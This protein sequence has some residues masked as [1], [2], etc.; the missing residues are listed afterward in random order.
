MDVFRSLKQAAVDAWLVMLSILTD[1]VSAQSAMWRFVA[2]LQAEVAYICTAALQPA[3]SGLTTALGV[4]GIAL[5]QLHDAISRVPQWMWFY[6]IAPPLTALG[7]RISQVEALA[8]LLVAQLRKELNDDVLW[9]KVY[10][11]LLVDNET[12]ARIKDVAAARKYA[13]DLTNALHQTIEKEAAAGYR[14]GKGDRSGPLSA[15]IADLHLRGLISDAVNKVLVDAVKVLVTVES[16]GLEA[17]VTRVLAAVIKRTGIASDLGNY[18]YG[19]II[20]GQGGPDPKDLPSVLSDVSHRLGAIEDWI[21]GFMLSG[22]PEVEEAGK[23][24]KAISS[25]AVD[26]ALLAFFGQAVVA[27]DAWAREVADTVGVVAND[28][29]GAIVNLVHKA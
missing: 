13:L 17:V 5:N 12:K 26:G 23:Q 10:I 3:I 24:W 11:V 19:L 28:S 25:L 20:P 7:V 1:P 4:T 29:F 22:G 8:R 27:P 2:A 9:L 15:I 18:L 14:R 6:M 21:T 16:P